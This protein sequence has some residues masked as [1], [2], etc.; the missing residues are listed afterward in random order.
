MLKSGDIVV[1]DRTMIN[2]KNYKDNKISRLSVVLFETEIDGDVF[3]CTAPLT[4]NPTAALKYS[5]SY[6]S[7]PFLIY[8][9]KKYSCVKI[10]AIHMYKSENVHSTGITLSD[11]HMER[12]YEK[13][14]NYTNA[15]NQEE[16]YKMVRNNLI[17]YQNDSVK[18][19]MEELKIA[20]QRKRKN[21]QLKRIRIQNAKRGI[22]LD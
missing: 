4:N 3:V 11:Y 6:Y 13:V 2:N 1:Q 7:S 15:D 9:E 20:R 16:L 17:K 22:N 18:L 5:D 8:G 14:M 19:S 10:N 12:I 21:K